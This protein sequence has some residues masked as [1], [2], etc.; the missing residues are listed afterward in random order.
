MF[1]LEY[2][3]KIQKYIDANLVSEKQILQLQNLGLSLQSVIKELDKGIGVLSIIKQ[4]VDRQNSYFCNL[5]KRIKQLDEKHNKVYIKNHENIKKLADKCWFFPFLE[6]AINQQEELL[7]LL[8][9]NSIDELEIELE[10]FFKAEQQKIE[11]YIIQK[12][13]CLKNFCS[14]VFFAHYN[15]KYYLSVPMFFTLVDSIASLST[16]NAPYFF[17]DEYSKKAKIVKNNLDSN[18][19]KNFYNLLVQN[20]Y[21]GLQEDARQSHELSNSLN[22]HVVVHGLLNEY[23]WGN[24]TDSLKAMSL[25]YFIAILFQKK[26]KK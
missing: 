6:F 7:S 15:K 22:R 19:F 9:N 20:L 23:D 4:E 11:Q 8:G 14:E 21:I 17:K 24:E 10:S 12:Y 1:N 25:A 26:E 2:I 13:P 16:V 3:G 5:A 18:Y